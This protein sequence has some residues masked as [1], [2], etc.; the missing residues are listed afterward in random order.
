MS[1]FALPTTVGLRLRRV[2]VPPFEVFDPGDTLPIGRHAG[3]FSVVL[4]ADSGLEECSAVLEVELTY[5]DGRQLSMLAEPVIAYPAGRTQ[6]LCIK[7]HK[8]ERDEHNEIIRRAKRDPWITPPV[9][10]S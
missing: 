1:F 10:A 2:H 6:L 5:P 8:I 7:L 9:P 4:P 3:G